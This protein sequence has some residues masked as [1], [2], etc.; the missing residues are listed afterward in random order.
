MTKQE[1]CSIYEKYLQERCQELGL[2]PREILEEFI[3][4]TNPVPTWDYPSLPDIELIEYDLLWNIDCDCGIENLETYTEE[5]VKNIIN[6]G[7][8]YR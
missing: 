1:L 5:D 2:N 8:E 3:D 7:L 4:G 6:V